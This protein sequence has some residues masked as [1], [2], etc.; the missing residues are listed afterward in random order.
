V[1]LE[2]DALLAYGQRGHLFRSDDAGRSWHQIAVATQA[3]LAGAVRLDER[4]IV[5]AG[6]EG[7]ML[8]STDGGHTFRVHQE[9]DRKGFDAAAA[10]PGG[11]VVCGEAGARRLTLADLGSGG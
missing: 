5:I 3:L 8:V 4:T 10:V 11:V 6:L 1:A 7:A 9:A 2:G